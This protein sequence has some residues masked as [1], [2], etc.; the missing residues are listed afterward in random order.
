MH[1]TGTSTVARGLSA[2]GVELGDRLMP[3]AA[4]NEKGFWEDIDLYRFNE[5]LLARLGHRWDY[6]APIRWAAIDDGEMAG[7]RA[8]AADLLRAKVG[9]SV[10]YGIKDPRL[11]VLLPFWMPVYRSAGMQVSSVACVR[12]PES[13]AHSLARR[14]GMDPVRSHLLWL[15]H[16]CSA[17]HGP[18]R[19]ASVVV[20]Y[21]LLITSPERELRRM[22]VALELSGE[23]LAGDVELFC[24]EFVDERL[25]HSR[26]D[27]GKLKES[28]RVCPDVADV[29]RLARLCATDELSPRDARVS[30]ATALAEAS[31]DGQA[32]LLA[33]LDRSEAARFRSLETARDVELQAAEA[34]S[35][36]IEAGRRMEGLCRELK[37][38]AELA[39]AL[40]AELLASR[41]ALDAQVATNQAQQSA[42]EEARQVT[43]LLRGE[44]ATLQARMLVTANSQDQRALLLEREVA[45]LRS[46]LSWKV[47][48]PLRAGFDMGRLLVGPLASRLGLVRHA[49]PRA[50]RANGARMGQ[51][52]QGEALAQGAGA[53]PS[54]AQAASLQAALALAWQGR[55]KAERSASLPLLKRPMTS[56][57]IPVFGKV[58]Y[59]A[60]CL[61]SIWASGDRSPFE[62]I[63]VD[64]CSPDDTPLLLEGLDGVRVVSNE[65]NQGFLRSC[66]AAASHCRGDF[67]LFL[68]NDT[69]VKP[70]WLDAM[71]DVF[72]R[73]PACGLVGCKLIYP[74]GAL[75]EAGGIVW[76]DGSA[77]NY[78]RLS[79]AAASPFNY[80]REVDY[81]S[82][83]SILLKRSLF[84]ELGGFDERYLPAYYEDTDLAF[85][86]RGAG[87]KVY[88]QP[89]SVVIHHEGV[90]HGTDLSAGVKAFQAANQRKFHD[91]WR[92]VLEAEHFPNADS[93]FIAR[94]RSRSRR[95]VVVVDHY[96]P[97]PDQDAGSRS[98][99]HIMQLLV[100]E[101]LNV[102]FWP[103]NLW[104]DP[105]YTPRLQQLGVE[106]FY[107]NE[108][109][110]RF[111]PW[112]RENARFVD[113]FL[114][115]RPDVARDFIDAIRARTSARVLY[116][117]HDIH[118]LR[119]R[120]ELRVNPDPGIAQA[121]AANE[122]LE[123]GIWRKADF[124]YQPSCS[125]TEHIDAYIRANRLSARARTI[126]V[127]SF[128]SF[129]EA[130]W[131]KL[132]E[133]AG[134]LFVAGFAHRPNIDAAEWLL[135]DVMPRV[136][137]R[138]P[139]VRLSL[140]GSNPSPAVRALASPRVEVTGF[141]TDDELCARYA[142]ARVAVA[143]LRYG[144]GMK[145]KVVE[146]MR[147]GV[148]LVTTPVG[149]QGLRDAEAFMHAAED[150][151]QFADMLVGLLEDGDAWRLV[152]KRQLEFAKSRFSVAALREALAEGFSLDGEAV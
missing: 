138:V 97:Q 31:L 39:D 92:H 4:D 79:D 113:Y 101:G 21:D 82:G 126:P 80:V 48:A 132:A 69:E 14:S 46:S 64:D 146:A 63:V 86:V 47:T 125:E 129:A 112:V 24:S 54:Q 43:V 8:Q 25:R 74:G 128:D 56:I 3:A 38:S 142:M 116:Y 104:F 45:A 140:V 36:L 123:H 11:C 59:T 40:K 44:V 2:L 136:W 34:A 131:V 77:W 50:P 88:Y 130:P 148:P 66:N 127:Y 103:H 67:V 20:D 149:L 89:G 61:A 152:S 27:E 137:E 145:G 122:R 60:R 87:L 10:V 106:V 41:A 85:K 18:E 9:E 135:R 68:N 84:E 99:W 119:L 70:G 90:S 107:G 35:Q 12:H 78:G 81:C 32:Q 16:T 65:S 143:P 105:V 57:V 15:K 26:F 151:G 91:R 96:V 100:S 83:A 121:A 30:A 19:G 133:R 1:R 111:D 52:S 141:V 49:P 37:E 147:F 13:V 23:G 114:L 17:I 150:P 76:R 71:H 118:H 95:C 29:Y 28:Q 134:I 115:S 6:V 22:A 102:K 42:L 117:G 124:I 7:L 139:S 144:G 72:Q 110:D 33:C 51:P 73:F 62:V 108:Y 53:L 58:E 55:L 75:Q 93:V 109:V 5:R 98:M 120:D 94:D